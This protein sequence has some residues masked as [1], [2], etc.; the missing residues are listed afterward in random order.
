MKHLI[1]KLYIVIDWRKSIIRLREV[2][3]KYFGG[4]GPP[5]MRA[6]GSTKCLLRVQRAQIHPKARKRGVFCPEYLVY[7]YPVYI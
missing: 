4:P 1:G 6:G 2:Y 5:F 7:I 3:K